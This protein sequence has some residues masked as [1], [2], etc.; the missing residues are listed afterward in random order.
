M[1]W[2]NVNF[3]EMLKNGVMNFGPANYGLLLFS[4][5]GSGKIRNSVS[6]INSFFYDLEPNSWNE[7][8]HRNLLLDQ[9][10]VCALSVHHPPFN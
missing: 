4:E 9:V 5:L 7:F 3:H 8:S 2:I 10:D 6:D 1:V